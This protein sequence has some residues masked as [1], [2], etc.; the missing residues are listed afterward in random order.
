VCRVAII[1]LCGPALP[2]LH[3]VGAA[4]ALRV[5]VEPDA[6]VGPVVAFI[7]AA[8]SRLDGEVYLASSKPVLAA[9]ERAAARG[10][11]VRVLLE[12]HPYGT[13][14]AVPALVYRS[15]QAHG[16]SVG[17]A[18]PAFRYTHAKFMVEPD[19]GQALIGT[20]N[21]TTSAFTKNREFGVIDGD[22]AVV[23]ESEAVFAADLRRSRVPGSV[24]ALVVSPLNAR[25]SLLRLIGVARRTLE[26]YAEETY[27]RQIEAALAAAVRR[28]VRVRMVTT[29]Q[30]DVATLER[31]GVQVVIR[32]APYIHAKAIVADQRAVF[33]GSENLSSTSLDQNREMGL[34]LTETA[35]INAVETA[36][37][38]DWQGVATAAPG[39]PEPGRTPATATGTLRVQ[40]RV[41]PNPTS[42]GTLTTVTAT[43]APRAQCSVVVRYASGHTSGSRFLQGLKETDS[44]GTIAWSWTPAT[45]TRGAAT[46][47]VSCTLGTRRGTGVAR[48]VV[49]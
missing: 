3:G 21:W 27:D 14:S 24:A 17:W 29:G 31:A 16:V 28:G 32:Q 40:V 7:D 38:A 36:F 15:L 34:V 20:M 26:V 9:L 5:F 45:R 13:G 39:T 33:I 42:D 46:A 43:T 19:R 8:R 44:A 35:A 47:T 23:G 30:G 2:P 1:L 49:Q 22:P 25:A 41:R 6:G 18:N 12:Q 48:F 11:R 10:V 4:P 37:A